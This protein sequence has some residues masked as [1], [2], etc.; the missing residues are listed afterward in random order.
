MNKTPLDRWHYHEMTDRAYLVMD[1]FEREIVDHI[2]ADDKMLKSKIKKISK[3]LAELYQDAGA[4]EDGRV[5]EFPEA[6]YIKDE[7]GK[8]YYYQDF[9]NKDQ[10]KKAR[11]RRQ[12]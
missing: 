1:I 12:D 11:L 9:E 10:I 8:I 3:L 7:N 4:L 6:G 5:F 2:L